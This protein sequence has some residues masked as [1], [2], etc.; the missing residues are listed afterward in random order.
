[1]KA[2]LIS[3]LMLASTNVKAEEVRDPGHG[4]GQGFAAPIFANLYLGGVTRNMKTTNP[5]FK[6]VTSATVTFNTK[7]LSLMLNKAPLSCG[8]NM[9]CIQIM[10]A[11]LN[12]KLDVISVVR[13]A[14]SVIY[15]AV[16]PANV[17]SEVFEVVTVQD[18]T[19]TTCEML[20][21]SVGM[22]TYQVT[23]TSSLS[24]KQATATANFT[25]AGDFI[26]AQN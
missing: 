25:V 19:F 5:R 24:K 14:C 9:A 22:V 11:P 13:N 23:G 3:L 1:M 2:I 10:P 15:T 20:L 7:S 6:S 21:A 8:A 26:R 17:K 4:F 18:F 16:T 12:I